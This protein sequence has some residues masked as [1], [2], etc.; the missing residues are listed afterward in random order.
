MTTSHP[1]ASAALDATRA[2]NRSATKPR[3][4][5]STSQTSGVTR[6]ATSMR[7]VSAP[8]T[9]QPITAYDEASGRQSVSAA[10]TPAAAVRSAVTAAASSTASRRPSSA[11]D[12][13][14]SPVTVGS[15]RA[16]FPG[17]DVT[18]LR[19]A[20]PSPIAGIARKSP[21]G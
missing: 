9:P 7:V 20:W 14:T 15:P 8:F 6:W 13:S 19:S 3:R 10:R 1:S 5:S 12:R 2:P 11:S 18:H 16:G 4:A 17:K 21:A